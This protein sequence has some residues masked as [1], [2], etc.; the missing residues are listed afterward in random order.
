MWMRLDV[1][2]VEDSSVRTVDR[3]GDERYLRVQGSCSKK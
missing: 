1:D 2:G 3:L